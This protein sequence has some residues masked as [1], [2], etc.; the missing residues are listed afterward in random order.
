M[1]IGKAAGRE[2]YGAQLGDA[3][4]TGVVEV[5]KRKAGPGHRILQERDRRCSW[6]A[7]LPAQ[8]QKSADKAMAAV[9]VVIS[10]ARPVA[11]VGKM[12]EHQIEQL[13]RLRD[14]G[15][16][17]WFESP[18]PGHERTVSLDAV[19]PQRHLLTAN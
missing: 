18:D 9:S 16:R 8:M 19:I 1:I 11:V 7:M 10:A 6:Q 4:A 15:F 3:A 5:H 12:L 2:D 13:H 17:H 14:L